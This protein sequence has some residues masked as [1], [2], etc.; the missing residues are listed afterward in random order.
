MP[1]RRLTWRITGGGADGSI[2][3]RRNRADAIGAH[4][5]FSP[6]GAHAPGEHD[7]RSAGE[8]LQHLAD[9]PCLAR[10]GLTRDRDDRTAPVRH[11]RHHRREQLTLV[12]A[13]DERD[14]GARADRRQAPVQSGD[15]PDPL[16]LLAAQARRCRRPDRGRSR[17][18]RARRWNRRCRP[19]PAA[20]SSAAATPRSPRR[21]SP[22]IPWCR[23]RYRP[24][25]HRC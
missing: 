20:P 16:G 10:S 5:L 9:E 13:T 12:G 8:P 7:R 22:C 4:T 6:Y 21:P 15:V 25:L 23:R 24:P 3:I 17:R 1:L 11:H 2:P 19:N 18:K 14:V